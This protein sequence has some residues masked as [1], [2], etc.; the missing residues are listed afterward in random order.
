[1]TLIADIFPEIPAPKNMVILRSKKSLFRGS[2]DR[3]HGK[4]VETM[5]Q[6]E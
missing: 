1:M 3:E 6:S 5:F 2:L 4:W